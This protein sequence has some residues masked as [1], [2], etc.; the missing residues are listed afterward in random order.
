MPPRL[1]ASTI[2]RVV[3][4]FFTIDRY[5]LMASDTDLPKNDPSGTSVNC[6]AH[7]GT[8][9][10]YWGL[11]KRGDRHVNRIVRPWREEFY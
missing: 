9:D 2:W 10:G 8:I 7:T 4:F 6:G 5:S 3:C 11:P 1:N